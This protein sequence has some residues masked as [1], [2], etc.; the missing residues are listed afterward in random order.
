MFIFFRQ[1]QLSESIIHTPLRFLCLI[2]LCLLLAYFLP[3]NNKVSATMLLD[4]YAL[5]P[6]GIK[7]R[8]VSI[9]RISTRK[10]I[11]EFRQRNSVLDKD[12]ATFAL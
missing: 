11:L 5:D 12:R 6:K 2:S 3:I 4:D 8:S 9:I 7:A 1:S 10:V